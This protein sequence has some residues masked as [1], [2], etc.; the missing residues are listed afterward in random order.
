[1]EKPAFQGKPVIRDLSKVPRAGFLEDTQENKFGQYVFEQY[2]LLAAQLGNP[3]VLGALN[4]DDSVVTGSNPFAAVAVNTVLQRE[5]PSCHVATPVELEEILLC[6][7]LPLGTHYED[8]ALVLRGVEQPNSYLATSLL[9]QIKKMRGAV[10][11][12]PVMLPL[13]QLGLVEDDNSEYG[14][15]FKFQKGAKPIHAPQLAHENIGRQFDETNKQG[16]PVFEQGGQRTF[17]T[18]PDGLS[19]LYLDGYADLVSDWDYLGDSDSDGR[20]VVYGAARKNL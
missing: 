11:K 4:Y 15:T 16:L 6:N 19:G 18:I 13:S 7:T 10:P 2:K 3:K 17:Y 20:V 12:L 1:M 14:L 9:E 5:F 8:T